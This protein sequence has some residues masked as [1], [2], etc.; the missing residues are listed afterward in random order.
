[1]VTGTSVYAN[2]YRDYFRNPAGAIHVDIHV[3]EH[4]KTPSFL[5]VPSCVCFK[6]FFLQPPVSS[7]SCVLRECVHTGV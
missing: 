4:V 7:E 6:S 3:T 5:H 2:N 1:M